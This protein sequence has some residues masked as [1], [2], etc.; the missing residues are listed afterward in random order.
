MQR[1]RSF[2]HGGSELNVGGIRVQARKRRSDPGP[3][4]YEIDITRKDNDEMWRFCFQSQSI[5]MEWLDMLKRIASNDGEIGSDDDDDDDDDD[6][7]YGLDKRGFQPGDHIIRWEMLPIL[8]PIQVHGIVLE[9]GKNCVIIADFGLAS[10]NT[11]RA[12]DPELTTL[13]EEGNKKDDYNGNNSNS[14]RSEHDVIMAAW[15]KIKPKE[16]KRLNVVVVTDPKEVRKWSK[17]N[18][19]DQVEDKKKKKKKPGFL[20]SL[21]PW[22]KKSSKKKVVGE[23]GKVDEAV[24]E[25]EEGAEENESEG[26]SAEGTN[27]DADN[28]ANEATAAAEENDGRTMQQ[29]QSS[30]DEQ[31]S[32]NRIEGAPE[33]IQPGYRPR[34][35]TWSSS[36]TIPLN[37]TGQSVFS[38]DHYHLD[39]DHGNKRELPKSDSAKLVLARTHFILENEDLLPPYH[40]SFI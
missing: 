31:Q 37:D 39:D 26:R 3:T 11:R 10:H 35:R 25:S 32:N 2:R 21:M 34:K 6:A 13:S 1:L 38:I 9:A 27:D 20:K 29:Q 24:D 23:E 22:D 14:S 28:D 18:Y 40:V 36:S 8:Y 5:Q 7:K 33:W 12:V 19:G 30:L 4:P 15:E 17:V 16:K